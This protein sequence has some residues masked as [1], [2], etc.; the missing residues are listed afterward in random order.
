VDFSEPLDGGRDV[1]LI[2]PDV[3]LREDESVKEP[4]CD[5]EIDS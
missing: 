1:F 3:L 4:A 2:E 5:V